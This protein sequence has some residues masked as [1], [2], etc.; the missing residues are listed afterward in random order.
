MRSPEV[1]PHGMSKDLSII[2]WPESMWPLTP[3]VLQSLP[4]DFIPDSCDL[5]NLKYPW[6]LLQLIHEVTERKL[7]KN[8]ISPEAEIANNVSIKGPVQIEKGAKILDFVRIVGPAYVGEG[9]LIGNFNLIRSSVIGRQ[10]I[11]GAHSEVARSYIGQDCRLHRNVIEDSIVADGVDVSG[12]STT[13]NYRLDHMPVKSAIGGTKLDSGL[14]KLGSFIGQ[15][16][17]IGAN[18]LMMPGVK[19]GRDCVIMPGARIYKDV[20]DGSYIRAIKQT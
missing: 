10:S 18:C 1:N 15:R 16:T 11:V 9:A 3:A 12:N 4:Q 17:R 6:E 5:A 7:T 14:D 19:I 2:R 20:P 13:T 8:K